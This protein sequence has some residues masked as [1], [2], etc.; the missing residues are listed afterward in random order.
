M[1]W[2]FA[3]S[4]IYRTLLYIPVSILK[5]VGRFAIKRLI[6]TDNLKKIA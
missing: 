5:K 6:F 1:N 2:K 4:E 3:K